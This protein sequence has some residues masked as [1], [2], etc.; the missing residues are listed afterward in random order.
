MTN[1]DRVVSQMFAT[2]TPHFMLLCSYISLEHNKGCEDCP[3]YGKCKLEKP[4]LSD[5]QLEDWL[6]SREEG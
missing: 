6:T 2:S 3:I 5:D 1:F 4:M